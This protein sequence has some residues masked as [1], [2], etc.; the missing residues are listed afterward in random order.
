[1]ADKIWVG[2]DTGNEGDWATADN[3]SPSGVPT[4]GDDV[5]IISGSQSITDGY[6][7]H[8]VTLSSLTIIG[9]EDYFTGDIG[10]ATHDLYID[11][12]DL[13]VHVYGDYYLRPINCA[14]M[15][16]LD[17]I[18]DGTLTLGNSAAADIVSSYVE[19]GT[20]ELVT[21]TAPTLDIAGGTVTLGSGVTWTT[22]YVDGGEVTSAAAGGAGTSLLVAGG[23]M[24]QS[25]GDLLSLLMYGGRLVWTAQGH[26]I[27]TCH[28]RGGRFD[29]SQDAQAKT[30]TT[31]Q[32]GKGGN[33][34]LANGAANIVVTNPIINR[35]GTLKVDPSVTASI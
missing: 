34:N 11:V 26:T 12:D 4:N 27:T 21:V 1:M 22:L 14:A 20:L 31:L 5:F 9:G 7:Q 17:G 25:D 19:G 35:G 13:I 29:A 28:I 24:V 18:G 10:D 8:T 30:I 23:A 2:T 3:W 16:V 15:T 6:D 32:I 33:A